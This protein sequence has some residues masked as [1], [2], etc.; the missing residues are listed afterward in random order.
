MSNGPGELD[1]KDQLPSPFTQAIWLLSR[2]PAGR[3]ITQPSPSGAAVSAS[4]RNPDVV[5]GSRYSNGN[6]L[7]VPAGVVTETWTVPACPAGR[8]KVNEVPSGVTETFWPC[9]EPMFTVVW[10]GTNPVPVRVTVL[11]P[12]AGPDVGLT[13]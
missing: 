1:W 10:L 9:A 3:Q 6:C 12:D 2:L 7:L 4:R 13:A 8:V 11:P 5:I